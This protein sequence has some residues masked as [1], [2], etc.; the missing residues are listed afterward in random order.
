[1]TVAPGLPDPGR[2]S[3]DGLELDQAVAGDLSGDA[4]S[5]ARGDRSRPGPVRR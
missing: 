4:W 5:R 3:D 2:D 1:M